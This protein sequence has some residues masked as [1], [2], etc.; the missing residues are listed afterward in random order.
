MAKTNRDIEAELW[1]SRVTIPAGTPVHFIKGAGGGWVVSSAKLL[2]DLTGNTH[3][4]KY[5]YAWINSNDVNR[6]G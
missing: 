4:P 3:D 1:G 6:E 2:M 5:R